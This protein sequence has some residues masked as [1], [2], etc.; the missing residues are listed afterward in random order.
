VEIPSQKEA[1]MILRKAGCSEQVINHCITVSR[2]A[3][4]IAQV[5][6]KK[7][8]KVD[9]RLVE[10]GGLLHD[11]GRAKTHGIR[12]SVMGGEIARS[13]G[14]S[15]P[16]ISI[17]E[18]HIGAGISK[19]E[20]KVLE[21]PEKSY[22]PVTLEEKIV[23]YA[24]KLIEGDRQVEIDETIGKFSRQLGNDHPAIGRLR[25]LHTFFSDILKDS[26]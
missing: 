25:A 9:I 14:L 19:E 20:A 24:D 2:L 12:H 21:I 17:I 26:K 18:R 13:M 10:I 7:G 22:I 15:E 8:F 6:Q 16:I 11:L 4:E 1:I 5:C 3:K 23:S